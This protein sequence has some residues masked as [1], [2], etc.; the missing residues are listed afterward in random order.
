MKKRFLYSSLILLLAFAFAGCNFGATGGDEGPVSYTLSYSSGYGTVPGDRT[1]N[2]GALITKEMLPA[3][4]SS[5]IVFN[6]WYIDDEDYSTSP[7]PVVADVIK[8]H[9]DTVL[10]AKWTKTISPVASV[11][12]DQIAALIDKEYGKVTAIGVTGAVADYTEN[13]NISDFIGSTKGSLYV[14]KAGTKN[15]VIGC[16]EDSAWFVYEPGV[17]LWVV[18]SAEEYVTLA[19]K[20]FVSNLVTGMYTPTEM[21]LDSFSVQTGKA[22]DVTE[23]NSSVINSKIEKYYTFVPKNITV[24]KTATYDYYYGYTDEVSI[25]WDAVD[26]ALLYRVYGSSDSTKPSYPLESVSSTSYSSY[27]NDGYSFYWVSAVN[28]KEEEGVLSK[29]ICVDDDYLRPKSISAYEDGEE[30][31]LSWYTVYGASKYNVYVDGSFVGETT[32]ASYKLP[33]KDF[34]EGKSY[35]IG[36][37][38][39]DSSGY[40]SKPKELSY[41]KMLPAPEDLKV[42]SKKGSSVTISWKEV[43]GASYYYIYKGTSSSIYDLGYYDYVYDVT[44]YTFTGL[45]YGTTYYFWV[46]CDTNNINSTGYITYTPEFELEPP[47]ITSISDGYIYYTDENP[48]Y[49]DY[50]YYYYIYVSDTPDM[51]SSYYTYDI[52]YSYSSSRSSYIGT[53]TGAKYV[54]IKAYSY[55]YDSYSEPSECFVYSPAPTGLTVYKNTD[56]DYYLKWNAIS[57]AKTYYVYKS[58]SNTSYYDSYATVTTNECVLDKTSLSKD[59]TYYFYVCSEDENGNIS[60][61]SVGHSVYYASVPTDFTATYTSYPKVTLS[62]TNNTVASKKYQIYKSTSF[63]FDM[64]TSLIT[65]SV[66]SGYSGSYTDYSVTSGNSYYYWIMQDPSSISVDSLIYSYYYAYITCE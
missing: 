10:H 55:N 52:F 25:S 48:E 54:W 21:S 53:L 47:V 18:G 59:T 26:G 24:S 37:T 23:W 36:V 49:Y 20:D 66:S 58:E 13:V 39:V 56:G 11:S 31:S 4:S 63:D 12:A 27:S 19:G 44:S 29:P 8:V 41:S 61:Y 7:I 2:D 22:W 50:Y 43:E 3:L 6:Y 5:G 64:A 62:W 40:E 1:L 42:S 14:C 9:K 30:I 65:K 45:E 46:A 16:P 28:K 35:I 34:K 33:S 57:T 60:D 32:T 15:L 38:A 17:V 51:P